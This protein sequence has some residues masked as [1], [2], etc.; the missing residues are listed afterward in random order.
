MTG[1]HSIRSSVNFDTFAA[2]FSGFSTS[3]AG[4]SNTYRL[5]TSDDRKSIFPTE[6]TDKDFDIGWLDFHNFDDTS[7][8]CSFHQYDFEKWNAIACNQTLLSFDVALLPKRQLHLPAFPAY[9]QLCK[10]LHFPPSYSKDVQDEEGF[11]DRTIKVAF[12]FV[13]IS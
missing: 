11:L 7:R 1:W 12:Q 9:F 6:C 13:L 10:F 4:V 8:C 5:T 3:N 2:W